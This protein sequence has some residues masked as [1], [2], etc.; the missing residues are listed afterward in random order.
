MKKLIFLSSIL[1]LTACSTLSADRNKPIAQYAQ[2]FVGQS[3]NQIQ[4]NFNLNTHGIP[5]KHPVQQQ[6]QQLIYTFERS[7]VIATPSRLPISDERGKMII[8]QSGGSSES[9]SNLM[10][11]H[12]IF[13]LKENIAQSFQLKGRAC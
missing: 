9:Y 12:I 2:Q 7:V 10:T 8:T 11:C 6:D 3:S 5:L 1:L 13:T 4:Q